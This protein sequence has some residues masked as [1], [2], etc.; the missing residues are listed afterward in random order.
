MLDTPH[1]HGGCRKTKPCW[2]SL[3]L[4]RQ[5]IAPLNSRS[6]ADSDTVDPGHE[7]ACKVGGLIDAAMT[8]SGG[9]NGCFCYRS[10]DGSRNPWLT[11]DHDL[12]ACPI[13]HILEHP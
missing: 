7:R 3:L 8:R 9:R 6:S 12:A 10:P 11:P 5:P 2:Q 4:L 13:S 1:V